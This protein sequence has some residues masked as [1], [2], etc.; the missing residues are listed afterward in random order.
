MILTIFEYSRQ[1]TKAPDFPLS[2]EERTFQRAQKYIQD[3]RYTGPVALSCDDTKLHAAYRTY[4]DPAQQ[5]H[6]L[7]GGIG[8]PPVVPTPDELEQL[9]TEHRDEKATK[10]SVRI[11]QLS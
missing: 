4:W 2:I 11:S 5:S 9:L 7:V 10:V 6:V 1:R 8:P 3:L